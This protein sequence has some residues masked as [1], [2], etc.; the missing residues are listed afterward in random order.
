MKI[1]EIWPPL[2]RINQVEVSRP[3]LNYQ[4]H[5]VWS[6]SFLF[7]LD[8]NDLQDLNKIS[9]APMVPA[10]PKEAPGFLCSVLLLRKCQGI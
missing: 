6:P 4:P 2:G 8:G 3:R 7:E 10:I 9:Q 5:I 1:E